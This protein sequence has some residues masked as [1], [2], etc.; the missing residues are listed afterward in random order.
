MRSQQ[1]HGKDKDEDEEMPDHST[2]S[3]ENAQH[4]GFVN[5][6]LQRG[7]GNLLNPANQDISGFRPKPVVVPNA[8]KLGEIA[9]PVISAD[10]P[11]RHPRLEW[12]NR[13]S[14][15]REKY[16]SK[17]VYQALK[18]GLTG[19]YYLLSDGV[20]IT[21]RMRVALK[22]VQLILGVYTTADDFTVQKPF[23]IPCV[24]SSAGTVN[25]SNATFNGMV[26]DTQHAWCCIFW[27]GQKYIIEK[28][29][30][31]APAPKFPE[32]ESV[33]ATIIPAIEQT[34]VIQNDDDPLVRIYSSTYRTIGSSEEQSKTTTAK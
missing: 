13:I 12:F 15:D 20:T 24:V 8:A 32:I 25:R 27:N 30:G 26:L 6:K 11:F 28:L 7:E 23:V 31:E 16:W 19:E 21:E 4:G 34:R 3:R 5:G 33:E 17:H 10:M 14:G 9:T 22:N 18:D 1:R 2:D 29:K